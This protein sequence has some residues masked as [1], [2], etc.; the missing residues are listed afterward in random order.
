LESGYVSELENI[1]VKPQDSIRT[2]MRDYLQKA[3]M[4][5]TERYVAVGN[6]GDCVI[7]DNDSI[8]QVS[9]SG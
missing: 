8:I 4:D 1:S 9:D 2:I 6:C 5:L 3:N 7:Y